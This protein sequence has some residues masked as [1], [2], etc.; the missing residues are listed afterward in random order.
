MDLP[1]QG[2]S[3]VGLSNSPGWGGSRDRPGPRRRRGHHPRRRPAAGPVRPLAHPAPGAHRR[4][5][6]PLHAAPRGWALVRIRT[7]HAGGGW[8][9]DDGAVWSAGRRLLATGRQARV[10]RERRDPARPVRPRPVR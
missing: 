3:C 6:P 1:T 4:T 5:D 9:V 8:A 7:G 2:Y 10:I